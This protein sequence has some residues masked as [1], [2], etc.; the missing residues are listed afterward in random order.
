MQ[1]VKKKPFVCHLTHV[2][3]FGTEVWYDL[4]SNF[5]IWYFERAEIIFETSIKTVTKN[6]NDFDKLTTKLTDKL[7]GED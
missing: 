3:V 1:K 4:K 6:R 5:A 2:G 7:T